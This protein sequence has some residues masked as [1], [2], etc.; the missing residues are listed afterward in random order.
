MHKNLGRYAEDSLDARI[1][2]VRQQNLPQPDNSVNYS[3]AYARRSDETL[4]LEQSAYSSINPNTQNRKESLISSQSKLVASM[5]RGDA[6]YQSEP[7]AF[8]I[9]EQDQLGMS[10]THGSQAHG[11]SGSFAYTS[12]KHV[13]KY[14]PARARKPGAGNVPMSYAGPPNQEEL[15]RNARRHESGNRNFQQPQPVHQAQ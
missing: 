7:G 15:T 10:R 12:G 6:L 13:P 11:S 2:Q 8:A 9:M 1:R 3:P 5:N 14:S 4:A